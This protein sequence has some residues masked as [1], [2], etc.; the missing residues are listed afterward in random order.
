MF[1]SS[2]WFL[3]FRMFS[4][5]RPSGTSGLG[6]VRKIRIRVFL[7]HLQYITEKYE[8]QGFFSGIFRGVSSRE[9]YIFS[10]L[11][12]STASP[13]RDLLYHLFY[14]FQAFPGLIRSS[15]YNRNRLRQPRRFQFFFKSAG[16]TGFF[17]HEP[18]RFCLF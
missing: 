14:R 18:G 15:D 3:I 2:I 10:C 13:H 7:Q 9:W 8:L 12:L 11:L 5:L 1:L 6:T 17:C 4:F 16:C